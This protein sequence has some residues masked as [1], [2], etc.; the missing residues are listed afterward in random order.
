M[1]K[2][3]RSEMYHKFLLEEG[4]AP[5]ID[6]DGNVVFKCEAGTYINN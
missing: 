6:D 5:K 2:Q 1:T 4:Y 3:Q